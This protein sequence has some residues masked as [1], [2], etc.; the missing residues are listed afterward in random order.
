VGTGA[1]DGVRVVGTLASADGVASTC[2]MSNCGGVL[3]PAVATARPALTA[4]AA[5][6]LVSSAFFNLS[7]R[8][9]WGAHPLATNVTWSFKPER[10]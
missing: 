10:F 7:P 9:G 1:A 8:S 6:M 3:P 2:T 5:M 4:T